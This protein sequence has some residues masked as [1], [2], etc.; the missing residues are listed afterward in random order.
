MTYYKSLS[1]MNQGIKEATQEIDGN[2][3]D[4]EAYKKEIEQKIATHEAQKGAF[5]VEA[6]KQKTELKN[7]LQVVVE[8]IE[9]AKENR[10]QI[11][12]D[13]GITQQA[14][15][16]LKSSAASVYG[17]DLAKE[18]GKKM[19]EHY[20]ALKE[21]D[22]AW[23]NAILEY[24]DVQDAEYNKIKASHQNI[25]G[26]SSYDSSVHFRLRDERLVFKN[27]AKNEA[28]KDWRF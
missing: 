15:S 2:I 3:L 17:E 7:E 26:P 25:W 1:E 8:T 12:K 27:K 21:I 24:S 22:Q 19:E 16:N 9:N 11:I 18:Y 20:K 4:L 13:L 14:V 5:S 28:F 10:K 6:T 23:D